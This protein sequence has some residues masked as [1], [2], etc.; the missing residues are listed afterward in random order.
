MNEPTPDKPHSL[1]HQA[2]LAG[3]LVLAVVA[4]LYHANALK[5]WTVDDSF[6]TYRYAENAA[7]GHGFVFNVGERVEGYTSFLWVAVLAVTTLV[8]LPIVA[9]SKILGVLAGIGCLVVITLAPR[10]V[11]GVSAY[12]AALAVLL[13]GTHGSLAVWSV[14]GMETTLVAFVWTSAGLAMVRLLQ[15]EAPTIRMQAFTGV[16][17]ALAAM[18]RPEGNLFAGVL[19]LWLL[20][21]AFR[22]RSWKPLLPVV[23]FTAIYGAYFICRFAYYGWLLPNTF[24]AKVGLGWKQL[25]NGGIYVWEFLCASWPL[26]LGAGAGAVA[27]LLRGGKEWWPILAILALDTAWIVYAGGDHMAAYRFIVPMLPLLC[28]IAVFAFFSVRGV[29]SQETGVPSYP[30]L[31]KFRAAVTVTFLIVAAGWNLH[32]RVHDTKMYA[33]VMFD[34]IVPIGKEVGEWLDRELPPDALV[35]TNTAGSVAYYSRRPVIDMLGLCDEAIGHRPI[36]DLGVTNVGHEKGDGKYVFSRHPEVIIWG[37]DDG[38]SVPFFRSDYELSIMPE[39]K[40]AYEYKEA[41][42]PSGTVL[43]YWRRK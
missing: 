9:T 35:A 19:G 20:P 3:A 43:K 16:L 11:R 28:M 7:A 14:S 5:A 18:A 23:V 27:L 36:K 6:I 30:F 8:G 38:E 4:F 37:S 1:A 42:L 22:A 12:A 2:L 29:S 34:G 24:Y 15:R 41:P 32:A 25:R 40:E 21:M 39:F 17:L 33:Y 26:V 10:W 31:R 13:L